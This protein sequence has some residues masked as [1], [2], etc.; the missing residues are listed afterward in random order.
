MPLG[1]VINEET[2]RESLVGDEILGGQDDGVA[3]QAVAHGVQARTLFAGLG[4]GAS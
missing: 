4:F 1:L 2:I 3:G